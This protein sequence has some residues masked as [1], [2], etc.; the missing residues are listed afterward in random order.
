MTT[1][2]L[3]AHLARTR[4]RYIVTLVVVSA[5][6]AAA[7]GPG[8]AAVEEPSVCA[9]SPLACGGSRGRCLPTPGVDICECGGTR[10]ER[11][12]GLRCE[13]VFAVD[14]SC[15]AGCSGHG[16]CFHGF[17]ECVA[18]WSGPLCDAAAWG[19]SHHSPFLTQRALLEA[20]AEDGTCLAAEPTSG[21]TEREAR[22]PCCE[23][24][25]LYRRAVYRRE[26][27]EEM[28]SLLSSLPVALEPAPGWPARPRHRTC[29]VVSSAS[30]L[31]EAEH[32]AEIDAH[33]TQPRAATHRRQPLAALIPNSA[34]PPP[35]ISNPNPAGAEAV[36]RMNR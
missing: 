26:S 7:D 2:Y 19:E 35:P 34:P 33:S 22:R 25:P 6:S 10:E 20:V 23:P 14:A 32:G 21:A 18:G 27:P 8:L 11:F 12:T 31:L 15:A 17:C 16:E 36:F 3:P 29:A 1:G 24:P 13:R 5:L 9:P 4:S 30:S 28:Q